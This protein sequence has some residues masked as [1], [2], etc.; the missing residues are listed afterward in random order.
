MKKH[1]KVACGFRLSPEAI[2]IVKELADRLGVSQAAV[3]ELALRK[4]ME[5]EKRK[6]KKQ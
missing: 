1:K 2:E 3:V 5:A 6:E 4:M